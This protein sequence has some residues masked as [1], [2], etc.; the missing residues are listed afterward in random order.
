MQHLLDELTALQLQ[1][2]AFVAS[3]GKLLKSIIEANFR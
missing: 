1:V 3:D 2:I